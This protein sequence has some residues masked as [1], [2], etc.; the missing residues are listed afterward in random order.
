MMVAP[1]R[2]ANLTCSWRRTTAGVGWCQTWPATSSVRHPP[3]CFCLLAFLG[4]VVPLQKSASWWSKTVPFLPCL[5]LCP[6]APVLPF[7]LLT[8]TVPFLAVCL[9][10]LSIHCNHCFHTAGPNLTTQVRARP[11]ALSSLVHP[12]QVEY[13]LSEALPVLAVRLSG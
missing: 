11:K 7:E 1:V 13:V 4:A 10:D 5:R 6:G 2:A 3:L 9:G 12:L 8:K